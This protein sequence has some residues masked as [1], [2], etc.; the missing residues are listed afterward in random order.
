MRYKYRGFIPENI[1]PKGASKIVVH[2]SEYKYIGSIPLGNLTRPSGE[3]LYSF[4][5]L[6]DLHCTG[7]NSTEGIRLDNAM[8]Y[9]E[10]Q[11]CSF[12]CHCGD[13]T[14]IGFWYDS[15]DTE[16]YIH[17]FAEYRSVCEKHPTLP[18]Y[19]ICGNH[20]SYNK[21]I[22]DNLDLLKEYT[23]ITMYYTM[24]H[25][26]DLFI[27]L[28]QPT[29]STPM[30]DDA[31]SWLEDTLEKNKNNRCFVFVHPFVSDNDSGNP[32]GVYANKIF[33]WWGDKT[34]V[35]TNLL[36]DHKKVILFHG[37]SHMHF[38]MQ[39]DVKNAIY[40]K[41]LG[42]HSVHVPSISWNRMIKDGKSVNVGGCYGYIVDVY[43][44][45]VTLNGLNFLT[46]GVVP[47][48]TYRIDTR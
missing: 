41:T 19:G 13:M 31:L 39:E 12:C 23:Q 35:F 6:S 48:G 36:N 28:S 4:G 14:N 30:S 10:E 8:K 43:E 29:G 5:L 11:G 17:Q 33:E 25:G 16:I 15:A 42:F 3:K 45:F 40:S 46:N 37:H 44:N 2:D 22:T 1:A 26:N 27:F 18:M 34:D 21:A 24:T 7:N 9:F 20:E 32:Y 38:A 47:L